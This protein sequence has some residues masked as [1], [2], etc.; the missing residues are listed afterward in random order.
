VSAK[1]QEAGILDLQRGACHKVQARNKTFS[2]VASLD[3]ARLGLA[4]R[5]AELCAPRGT[6]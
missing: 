1:M 5:S 3:E 6:K 4:W 2:P